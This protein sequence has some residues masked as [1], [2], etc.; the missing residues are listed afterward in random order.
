MQLMID[1]GELVVTLKAG[2]DGQPFVQRFRLADQ[3]A[4]EVWVAVEPVQNGRFRYLYSLSNRL[5]ARDSILLFAVDIKRPEQLNNVSQPPTFRQG[6][7]GDWGTTISK[8][9]WWARDE[10]LLAPGFG[11]GP[12]VSDSTLLPGLVT[13]YIRSDVMPD[14]ARFD[15]EL[16]ADGHRQ[17]FL[18]ALG[19]ENNSARR[20]TLG[21]KIATAPEVPAA[22]IMKAV[23]SEL[24]LAAGLPEFQDLQQVLLDLAGRVD[25]GERSS[26]LF[27]GL[28]KTLLQ[29]AFFQAMQWAVEHAT[30]LP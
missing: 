21:P 2:P 1:S 26:Q 16:L 4:P 6:S 29:Q 13:T 19:L 24:R 18:K 9:N 3:V 11:A 15:L 30:R 17:A 28:G 25:A 7:V 14:A 22:E 27:T 12:F 20:V 5:G 8:L 23:S 10:G